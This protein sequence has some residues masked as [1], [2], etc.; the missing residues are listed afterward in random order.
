MSKKYEDLTF[1]DDFMFCKILYTN[2]ELCKQLLELILGRKIKEIRYL[3][4]QNTIDIT[5]DGKGIRLDVYLE[6]DSKVYDIEMQTT[7][8]SNLPKRSRY[9][10]GMIDLNLIEKGAD[11][12]EL[13]E[14]FII[15]VCLHD[16]FKHNEC[17]YTF[18]NRCKEVQGLQL[19]DESTKIFLNASGN[20]ENLPEELKNFLDFLSGEEPRGQAGYRNRKK[21]RTGRTT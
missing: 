5:S 2:P 3:T 10:Q 17:V 12:S 15:F 19:G 11:Y 6:G 18:E 16:P 7:G 8:K 13:K 21:S 14:T 4:T 20:K 1:T 9:Y